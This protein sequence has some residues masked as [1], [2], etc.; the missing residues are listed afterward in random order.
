MLTLAQ[1]N[2]VCL[3]NGGSSQC[4]FLAEDDRGNFYCIKKISK[5]NKIDLEVAEFEKKQRAQ[6]RA[7]GI[8][9]HTLNIPIGD[10]CSGYVFF[11][12]RRQGYDLTED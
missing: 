7:Q 1:I 8:D 3:V 2:D 10:N 12:H 4:R 6:G 9:P 5:R 11:R